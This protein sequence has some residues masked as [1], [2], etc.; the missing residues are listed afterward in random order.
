MSSEAAQRAYPDSQYGV[1]HDFS[2]GDLLEA[3]DRGAV[4]ALNAAIKRIQQTVSWGHAIDVLFEIRDEW[5][6]GQ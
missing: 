6:V 5:E 2:H 1:F 4:E 3:F